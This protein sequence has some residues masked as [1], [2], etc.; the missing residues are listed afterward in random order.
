[1]GARREE[2]VFFH[3]PAEGVKVT[4]T[5]FI[6]GAET[7]L[8][9]GITSIRSIRIPPNYVPPIVLIVFALLACWGAIKFD[10]P[11]FYVVGLAGV[12]LG[13]LWA[14]R[15]CSRFAIVLCTAADE[16]RS[17]ISVDREF[18]VSVLRALN[19]AVI[20]RG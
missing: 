11:L 4:S 17:L 14:W 10:N 20:A 9:S 18:V 5:R 7:Y 19:E 3:D 1:V 13:G 2:I 8:L 16:N 6:V 15:L 12:G